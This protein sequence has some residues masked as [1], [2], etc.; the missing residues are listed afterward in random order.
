MT[1]ET[2]SEQDGFGI[3]RLVMQRGTK[4]WYSYDAGLTCRRTARKARAAAGVAEPSLTPTCSAATS[5][6]GPGLYGQGGPTHDR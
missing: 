1:T 6:P 5:P 2:W 4:R 3:A